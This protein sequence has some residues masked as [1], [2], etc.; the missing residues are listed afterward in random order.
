MEG[1]IVFLAMVPAWPFGSVHAHY[2][3]F[4]FAAIALLLACGLAR[5]LLLGERLEVACPITLALGAMCVLAMIQ[6]VPLEA[7][8]LSWLSPAT[9]DD[10]ESAGTLSLAPGA[11]RRRLLHWIALL[12]VWVIIRSQQRDPET[13]RRL[14]WWSVANGVL[15]T[16]VGLGQWISSPGNMVYWSIPTQGEVFGPFICRNHFAYYL[17]LCLGLTVGLLLGSRS[18]L[19]AA[20]AVSGR[21]LSW[22]ELL[23]DPRLLWL[24]CALGIM[25]TGLLAC[26]SRGGVFAFF[27]ASVLGIVLLRRA[28]GGARFG[29]VSLVLVFTTL[30]LLWLGFDRVSHRWQELWHDNTHGE[31]RAVVWLRCLSLIPQYPV[32]GSGLGTFGLVEPSTRQPG[33]PFDLWHEHAHN[34]YLEL[35]IEG[36]TSQMVLAFLVIGLILYKGIKAVMRWGPTPTGRLAVGGVIGVTAIALHSLVDFGLHV[37]AVSLFTVIVAAYLV[38]LAEV[39]EEA[40][41]TVPSS[42]RWC[43]GWVQA[44][45]LAAIGCLLLQF[46]WAEARAERCRL[47]SRSAP[48]ERRLELLHAALAYAPD[49]ADLHLAAAEAFLNESQLQP[50]QRHL[51]QAQHLSPRDLRTLVLTVRWAEMMRDFTAR[52][53]ALTRLQR[54]SPSEPAPW[55]REGQLALERQDKDGLCRAWRNVLP[56]GNNFLPLLTRA[57][58][59]PLTA[60]EF[61]HRVLPPDP[62]LIVQTL[63]E[64][65]ALRSSPAEQKRYL[66]AAVALLTGRLGELGGEE[67]VFKARLHG[68]LEDVSAACASYELALSR[69]PHTGRRLEFCEFLCQR[70]LYQRARQELALLLAQD[71]RHPQALALQQE[72]YLK[73][74]AGE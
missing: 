6:L 5:I 30:L 45:G 29:A 67:L 2:E 38:N 60:A 22:R 28:S 19:P 62:A 4:L 59:E 24:V 47:A 73:L 36:G 31:A 44:A 48:P 39:P 27:A 7:A 32:W 70:G 3:Q 69:Q 21:L 11:T 51:E 53:R 55:Y 43:N 10:G 20:A 18:L 17:N 23:R 40:A 33:D 52:D 66:T 37:P 65:D 56:R 34:D 9:L 13:F 35:W 41:V 42:W 12:A 71:P 74:A 8:W 46:G 26:L 64:T 50:A 58:P 63:D 25:L 68:R 54:L 49:R 1:I 61:L 72:V 14:A 15:L 16:V 57:I